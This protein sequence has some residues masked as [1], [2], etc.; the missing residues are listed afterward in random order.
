[1][2]VGMSAGGKAALKVE[3]WV[4]R[5]ELKAL[6]SVGATAEMLVSLSAAGL[7]EKSENLSA[8]VMDAH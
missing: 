3:M 4:G 7:V 1:M 5:W 8:V 6:R 2:S